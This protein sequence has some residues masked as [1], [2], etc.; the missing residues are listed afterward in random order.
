MLYLFTTLVIWAT[1]NSD[2]LLAII[3][4]YSIYI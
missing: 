4:K 3:E 2:S 1:I